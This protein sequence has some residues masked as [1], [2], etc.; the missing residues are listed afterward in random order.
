MTLNYTAA[1]PLQQNQLCLLKF[2]DG[3][4]FVQCCTLQST[5]LRRQKDITIEWNVSGEVPGVWLE[6]GFA[7]QPPVEH[8]VRHQGPSAAEALPGPI[9]RHHLCVRLP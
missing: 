6:A 7:A 5:L 3:P 4:L 2:R 9:A 8:A 1:S